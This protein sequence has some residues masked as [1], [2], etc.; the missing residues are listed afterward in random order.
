MLLPLSLS[1]EGSSAFAIDSLAM[2]GAGR[3][4][5]EAII[6]AQSRVA[7]IRSQRTAII[8]LETYVGTAD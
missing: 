8:L 7:E 2:P 5:P 1:G 3:G 6:P 4:G